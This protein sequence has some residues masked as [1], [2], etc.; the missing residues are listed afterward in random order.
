MVAGR[1]AVGSHKKTLNR[2]D[3]YYCVCYSCNIE[4]CKFFT[5]MYAAKWKGICQ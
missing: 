3:E 2:L 4:Y 1:A 5:C